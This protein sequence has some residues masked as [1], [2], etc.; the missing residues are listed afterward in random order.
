MLF[1]LSNVAI[2]LIIIGTKFYYR[3]DVFIHQTN[4]LTG[5][6]ILTT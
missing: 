5:K 4:M 1:N 3:P 2:Q 6:K